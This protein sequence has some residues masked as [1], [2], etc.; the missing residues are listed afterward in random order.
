MYYVINRLGKVKRGDANRNIICRINKLNYFF[1]IEERNFKHSLS[2][3]S[4]LFCTRKG[5]RN[6]LYAS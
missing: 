2:Y 5:K 3:G 4:N 1:F 6:D